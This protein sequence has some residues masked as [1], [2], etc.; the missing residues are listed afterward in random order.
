MPVRV[1]ACSFVWI[2]VVQTGGLSQNAGT[3]MDR[4][5]YPARAKPSTNAV[6]RLTNVSYEL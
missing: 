6:L 5:W 4:D 3:A 1:K 2:R